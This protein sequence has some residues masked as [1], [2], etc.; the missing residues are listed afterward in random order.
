MRLRAFGQ[1]IGSSRL[2]RSLAIAG[3][4]LVLA[5]ITYLALTSRP[6][7]VRIAKVEENVPVRVFGLGTVEARILSRVGFEVGA[8]IVELKADH[9]DLVKKGDVLAR[10][11]TAEQEAKVAR[12]KAGL[13]AAEVGVHRAEANVEKAH[14]VLAQRQEANKR[15]Q[16]LVKGNVVSEQIA[17]EA[18][19]D[20][21]VAR[22][23]LSVA[24][25]EVEVAR[26]SLANASA[27]LAFE[28]TILDHHTLSAP[29]DAMVVERHTEAGTV[30]RAG[31]SI[32][33]LV[34]PESVWGLAYV[35]ESRA[36]PIE[37]GQPAEVRLRS[38]PRQTLEAK[39]AR[40]GIESDRVNEERRI[41]VK[42]DTCPPEF[43]LGEQAEILIR[44][45]T[46]DRAL[47]VPEAAVTGYD[48]AKG[49]VWT[50]EDGR[51]QRRSVA[52]GHRTEDARLE[53]TGGL[54][55]GAAVVTEL[56]DG[57]REGRRAVIASEPAR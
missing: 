30:I 5:V 55:E 2:Y 56:S 52:I 36:G 32:F 26:A 33:T 38:L 12:A 11:H 20:E 53:I 39:V 25:S 50:L 3:G 19:R 4:I 49:M 31:D 13:L 42:C 34:A 1:A 45:A 8:A 57:F 18:Q 47:L 23:E 27:E 40:I 43:H 29:F 7:S 16:S 6:L 48:G 24:R 35:D 44:V 9:G 54:P 51:L 14:A 17:E 41:Y 10:L 15:K 37:I 46:L 21:D 22:A 28:S